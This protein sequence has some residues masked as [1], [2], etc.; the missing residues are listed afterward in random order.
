MSRELRLL[1]D[2]D[3]NKATDTDI[4]STIHCSSRPS[5]IDLFLSP[6]SHFHFLELQN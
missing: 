1:R 3:N 6:S 5:F 4:Q 2:V